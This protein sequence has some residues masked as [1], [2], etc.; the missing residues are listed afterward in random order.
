MDLQYKDMRLHY[1]KMDAKRCCRLE[2]SAN[3]AQSG[4]SRPIIIILIET[5]DLEPDNWQW[6]MISEKDWRN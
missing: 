3:D 6:W 5:P 4:L 2:E 1:E